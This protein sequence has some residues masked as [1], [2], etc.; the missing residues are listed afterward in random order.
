MEIRASIK[1]LKDV[2]LIQEIWILENDNG[3]S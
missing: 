2:A 1:D 3:A